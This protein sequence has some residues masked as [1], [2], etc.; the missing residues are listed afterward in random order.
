MTVGDT[1]LVVHR[2]VMSTVKA[3]N[4]NMHSALTAVMMVITD[5]AATIVSFNLTN[6]LGKF[7][8]TVD[9][10]EIIDANFSNISEDEVV[11]FIVQLQEM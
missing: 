3:R 5:P 6:A 9:P 1:D 11:W 10:L 2:P 8:L 7:T 4:V